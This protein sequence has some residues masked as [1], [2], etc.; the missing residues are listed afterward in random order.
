MPKRTDRP[1]I[2]DVAS[3]AGVS[4][5]TVS[6]VL[7]EP[8]RVSD[9]TR[10]RVRAAIDELGYRPSK[11][12]RALATN[13]T[14]TIGVIIVH[15]TL[16]GPSHM[17]FAIDTGARERGYVT[18]TVTVEDDTE[19][20]LTEAR[21]H[22]ISLGVD[23]VVV[24]AWSRPVLELAEAFARRIPTCAVT[25]GEV[26]DGVARVTSDN[27]EGARMAVSA[28][29]E[30]GCTRIGHLAGPAG[31]LEAEA[32]HAGWL[33][34][35]GERAGAVV[36]ADWQPQGGYDGV[37]QLLADGVDGIFCAN[38]LVAVGALKRLS[39]LGLRVPGDVALVGYDDIE[40]ADFLPVPLASVRQPFT[41][42]GTAAIT[43]LF[44]VMGGGEPSSQLLAPQYVPRVSAGPR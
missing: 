19:E 35:A 25:E 8:D 23:G 14:L 26:P 42:V 10:E 44:D 38:D 34:A 33:D 30:A 18:A 36:V 24:M 1:S 7:N 4:Y 37:D 3:V 12:A 40:I 41:D 6:R 43:A 17:S 5:Q 32:R 15:S 27:A 2:R 29:V 39:E 21:E 20:S 9:S 11:V 16:Y 31:W 13:D 22:L 28:L